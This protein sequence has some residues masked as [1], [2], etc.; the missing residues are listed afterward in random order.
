MQLRNF[1]N[2]FME[3][4]WLDVRRSCEW[5]VFGAVI[6]SENSILLCLVPRHFVSTVV[7]GSKM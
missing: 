4:R 3:C 6:E 7:G 1:L 5:H 2:H